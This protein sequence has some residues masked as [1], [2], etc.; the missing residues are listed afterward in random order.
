M[1]V[2][3]DP[4]EDDGPATVWE[5]DPGVPPDTNWFDNGNMAAPP[6]VANVPPESEPDVQR[7]LA[8]I[9]EATDPAGVVRAYADGIAIDPYNVLL[10]QAYLRRMVELGAPHMAEQQ[11]RDLSERNGQDG[12]AWAVLAY[13]AGTRGETETALEYALNAAQFLPDDT[14]VQRTAGQLLAWYDLLGRPGDFTPELRAGLE[15]LRQALGGEEAFADAYLAATD[16]LPA[17]CCGAG[18]RC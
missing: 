17:G 5:E 1:I 9:A 3:E 16:L 14:F 13:V 11:A 8:A 4:T 12:L 15:D 7:Y 18:H 2:A 6:G 10:E